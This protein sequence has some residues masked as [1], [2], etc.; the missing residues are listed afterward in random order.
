M[1]VEC[2]Q[3][4][5]KTL[6]NVFKIGRALKRCS[7]LPTFSKPMLKSHQSLPNIRSRQI[8]QFPNVQPHL[9]PAVELFGQPFQPA[10]QSS[11]IIHRSNVHGVRIWKPRIH[12]RLHRF[13]IVWAVQTVVSQ[14]YM[15][16]A[17]CYFSDWKNAS[18]LCFAPNMC[19]S[20]VI[21]ISVK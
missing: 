10:A 20:D 19:F 8:K 6:P 5:I 14:A 12:R 7:I 2:S 16:A 4:L 11:R 13:S 3:R 15:F 1:L 17:F 21:S 9:Q 18:V